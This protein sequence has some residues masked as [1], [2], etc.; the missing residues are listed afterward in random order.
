MNPVRPA[1]IPA[2][3]FLPCPEPASAVLFPVSGY[4]VPDPERK[5]S[6]QTMVSLSRAFAA[7]GLSSEMFVHIIPS[8]NA[9]AGA[10]LSPNGREWM[11]RPG[12]GVWPARRPPALWTKQDFE[13]LE[14]GHPPQEAVFPTFRISTPGEV[15][16]R[17]RATVY[18]T[19]AVLEVLTRD[20]GDVLVK[21]GTQLLLPTIQEPAYRSFPF[22]MPLL[23]AGSIANVTYDKLNIWLCGAS[24]YLRESI[25]DG[26]LLVISLAP[27][28]P[29][30]ESLGIV[31]EP[32]PPATPA[33][34]LN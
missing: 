22:Y 9:A 13:N 12:L 27:V 34:K 4:P 8:K 29:V 31:P 14:P 6:L 5:T 32:L 18:G 11:P 16:E 17:A 7:Q 15:R 28:R 21:R 19:G 23:D 33:A 20:S 1:T 25:D 30:L 2:A 3:R 24:V 26:G 10:L